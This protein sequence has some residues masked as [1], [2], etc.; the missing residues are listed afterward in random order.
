M[1]YI[2]LL[3]MIYAMK[4]NRLK[5]EGYPEYEWDDLRDGNDETGKTYHNLN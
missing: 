2:Y 3:L 4:F 1:I 5:A